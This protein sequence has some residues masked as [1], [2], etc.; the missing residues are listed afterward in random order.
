MACTGCGVGTYSAQRR[1]NSSAACLACKT[2][3]YTTQI[4]TAQCTP[5]SVG[6][7][8][9]IASQ[10]SCSRCPPR[11]T[12]NG[13]GAAGLRQCGCQVRNGSGLWAIYSWA[14]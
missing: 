12:T 1:A 5:C 11:T 10:K 3:T 4:G 14:L 8:G 13:T 2:G 9:V 6:T 7:Y